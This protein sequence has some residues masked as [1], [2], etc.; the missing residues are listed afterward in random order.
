MPRSRSAGQD[1]EGMDKAE[2][3][4]RVGSLDFFFFP[5]YN[6]H[7][8]HA[9]KFKFY[10]KIPKNNKKERNGESIQECSR[11]LPKNNF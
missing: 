9:S 2:G 11:F 1:G 7:V 4:D 10:Q 5:I 3:Y 6:I 8:Y